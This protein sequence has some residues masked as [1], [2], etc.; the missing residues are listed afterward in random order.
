MLHGNI[1]SDGITC[2]FEE[3]YTNNTVQNGFFILEDKNF[4]YEYNDEKLYSIVNND[5][6]TFII[7]NYD[8]NLINNINDH[9]V[10]SAMTKI[11]N[12]YPNIK[13]F[14]EFKD[15]KFVL[16]KSKEHHFLKRMSVISDNLNLSIFFYNCETSMIDE[17]LFK[18][19]LLI[20][21]L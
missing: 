19:R 10:T 2:D 20:D 21:N 17:K 4:R 5:R 15:M 12:D 18:E 7:Q 11:Y 16:E 9:A 14:Y 6:G 8:K 3:V 1:Y 13:K